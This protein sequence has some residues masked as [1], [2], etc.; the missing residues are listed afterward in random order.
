[1]TDSSSTVTFPGDAPAAVELLQA[2]RGGD[3]DVV[4]RLL[5]VNSDLAR[6]RF[7]TRGGTS[8][9]LHFVT[10]W[11]GYFPNGPEIVTILIDAGA[12]PDAATTPAPRETPLH[13]AASSDDLDVAVAL[14]DGVA[15]VETPGGSIGTP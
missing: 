11:P 1:M 15:D 6:A 10:D 14:V 4:R 9:A 7:E 5:S 8:T 13:W 3:V 2:V 12:D